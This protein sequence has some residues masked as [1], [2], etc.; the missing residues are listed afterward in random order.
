MSESLPPSLYGFE[1]QVEEGRGVCC[2][3][4][5]DGGYIFRFYKKD[6]ET[7]VRLSEGGFNAMMSVC[8]A[9]LEH[10]DEQKK[11]P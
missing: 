11:S 8:F 3:K 9:I 5:A 4:L 6:S 2:A 7:F 10:E 1:A